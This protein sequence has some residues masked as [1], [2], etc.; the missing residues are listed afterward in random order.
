MRL[1]E[2]PHARRIFEVP[3]PLIRA[4][5]YFKKGLESL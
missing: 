1:S 2:G 5:L 3:R 4:Y